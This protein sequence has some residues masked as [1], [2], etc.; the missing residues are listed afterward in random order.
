[1]KK[2]CKIE[3]K[4]NLVNNIFKMTFNAGESGFKRPGQYAIIEANG[5]RKPYQV[6]EFDSNRFTIVFPADDDI[7]RDLSELSP[8]DEVFINGGLGRGFN[9]QD[10]PQ[11]VC[12]VANG[13]GIPEMVGLAR[14]LLMRGKKCK[15]ILEYP[16]KKDIYLLESFKDLVNEI[17]IVTLDGS[18]GREGHAEDIVKD[19]DYVFAG[20]TLDMLKKLAAKVKEGQVSLGS[21]VLMHSEDYDDCF[22][23]TREGRKNC[24]DEGPVFD[25]SII[26]W[27]AI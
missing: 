18:N 11:E 22:I 13:L 3:N 19:S 8:G 14:S 26:N 25:M 7:S 15:T 16:S 6:C 17:E 2:T 10:A 21:T 27:D 1:M 5:R 24:S 4:E 20:G 9:S 12:I 23:E